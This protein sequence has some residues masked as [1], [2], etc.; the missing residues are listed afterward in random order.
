MAQAWLPSTWAESATGSWD[1][2]LGRA[3]R[4]WEAWLGSF[5]GVLLQTWL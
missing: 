5:L 4:S 2:R 1:Q 3:G